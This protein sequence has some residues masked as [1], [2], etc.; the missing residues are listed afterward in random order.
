[1]TVTV[2]TLLTNILQASPILPSL[3][4]SNTTRQVNL[5]DT[6]AVNGASHSSALLPTVKFIDNT[7]GNPTK[8]TAG[9]I[10]GVGQIHPYRLD[11][12]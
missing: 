2:F 3:E 9:L 11:L 6:A 7:L 8:R 10:C 5:T 4:T 1:M 12:V